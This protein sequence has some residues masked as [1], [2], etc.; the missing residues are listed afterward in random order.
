MQRKRHEEREVGFAPLMRLDGVHRPF[1]LR[2][3]SG[4]QAECFRV[5]VTSK[6]TAM[7]KERAEQDS[8]RGEGGTGHH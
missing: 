7:T 8:V 1:L 2:R 6:S 5:L 4:T 3:L